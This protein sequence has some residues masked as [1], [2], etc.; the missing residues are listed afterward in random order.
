[1]NDWNPEENCL[2]ITRGGARRC[3]STYLG[4]AQMGVDRPF[5]CSGPERLAQVIVVEQPAH[6]L[7]E[8]LEIVGI[9]DQE[10]G[11]AVDHLVGDAPDRAGNHGRP[12]QH[13]LGHGQ[14]ESLGEALL[15][16]DG[17]MVLEGVDDRG[18]LLEIVH[19]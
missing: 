13:R 10:P 8:F 18:V 17:G 7:A 19:R 15:D 4:I 5:T 12:L 6:R 11:F 16:D 2:N 1:M 3:M 9:L 14:P